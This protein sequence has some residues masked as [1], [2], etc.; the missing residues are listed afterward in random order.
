MSLMTSD[1]WMVSNCS[2]KVA[3]F[4]A[5]RCTWALPLGPW[6]SQ[7]G[8]GP[9]SIYYSGQKKSVGVL[10]SFTALTVWVGRGGSVA[11]EEE[12]SL[13]WRPLFIHVACSHPPP[14][15]EGEFLPTL[16]LIYSGLL[17]ETSFWS[18]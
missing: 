13:F 9:G 16:C 2:Q 5:P 17:D 7:S 4:P 18:V 10:D 15:G 6:H 8:S 3:S 1:M 14:P 11:E 12:K